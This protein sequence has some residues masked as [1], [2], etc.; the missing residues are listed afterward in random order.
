[1]TTVLLYHR[2]GFIKALTELFPEVHFD[3]IKFSD[4][5]GVHSLPNCSLLKQRITKQEIEW[6][7]KF[8]YSCRQILAGEQEQTVI[9]RIFCSK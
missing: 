8:I 1:M 6:N 5:Y 4:Q 2:G 9:P 7:E 3:E